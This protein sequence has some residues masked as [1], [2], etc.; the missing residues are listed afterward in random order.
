MVVGLS[1]DSA[2]LFQ[3]SWRSKTVR[4][5]KNGTSVLQGSRIIV[6]DDL[7]F[8]R[9]P[10]MLFLPKRLRF[11]CEHFGDRWVDFS[12]NCLLE[13]CFIAFISIMVD[14]KNSWKV[15]NCWKMRPAHICSLTI[16]TRC[17]A[18]TISAEKWLVG[19]SLINFESPFFQLALIVC[20]HSL[21]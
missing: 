10:K 6:N 4:S 8:K 18:K 17:F 3:R 15:Q 16:L 12:V 1:I 5:L 21:L 9:D 13:E 20:W 11:S 2:S 19:F 14:A 7:K